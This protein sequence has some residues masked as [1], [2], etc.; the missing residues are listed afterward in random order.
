MDFF[1]L[2]VAFCLFSGKIGEYEKD[3]LFDD[4]GRL[5]VE[6]GSTE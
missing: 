5:F 1:V 3:F 2:I 6:P 4:F